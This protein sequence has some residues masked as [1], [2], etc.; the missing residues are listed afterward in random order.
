LSRSE[1]AK[2]EYEKANL[3]FLHSFGIWDYSFIGTKPV[4]SL[5]DMKGLKTRTFGYFSL[6]WKALGGVPVT[7]AMP[8]VY[9][10][11]QSGLLD[12]ALQDPSTFLNAKY[13]EVAK[14]FTNMHFGCL[15]G[16]FAMNL[17]KWNSLPANVQKAMMEVSQ[18]MPAH[19]MRIQQ[20]FQMGALEELKK[21]GVQVYELSL[22]DQQKM[23]SIAKE[24]WKE[25]ATSM[26]AK[27]MPGTKAMDTW[28]KLVN[29][30]ETLKAK[31]K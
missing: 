5:A 29:K 12:G 30:H 14:H 6:P 7:M 2:T 4:K 24:V 10:A 1:P 20:T 28:I 26:D 27:G 11:F 25:I 3:K 19:T 17:K 22:A 9:S 16:P 23:R 15:P 31:K 21:R 8:E 18:E 13:Y